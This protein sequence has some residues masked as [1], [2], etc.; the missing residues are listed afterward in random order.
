MSGMESRPA[1]RFA[2]SE[3]RACLCLAGLPEQDVPKILL[4]SD[5]ADDDA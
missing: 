2:E 1:L 4:E 5:L 3:I